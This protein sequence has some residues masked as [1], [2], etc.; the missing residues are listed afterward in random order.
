MVNYFVDQGEVISNLDG[1]RAIVL[2]CYREKRGIL[3]NSD[4]YC[5]PTATKQYIYLVEKVAH[6]NNRFN[7]PSYSSKQQHDD[8]N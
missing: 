2:E 8:C 6:L 3:S 4:C 5:K 7:C 1:S